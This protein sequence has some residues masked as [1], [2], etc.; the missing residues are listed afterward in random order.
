MQRSKVP[1][2]IRVPFPVGGVASGAAPTDGNDSEIVSWLFA[3]NQWT[4]DA[5]PELLTMLM[6]KT[7]EGHLAWVVFPAQ[8]FRF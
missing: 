8:G 7:S 3:N 5:F 6:E 1:G 4:D 2:R